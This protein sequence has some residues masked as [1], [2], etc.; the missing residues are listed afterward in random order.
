MLRLG[1]RVMKTVA[2]NVFST[3]G[4]YELLKACQRCSECDTDANKCK[5]CKFADDYLTDS[6]ICVDC[7]TDFES[8]RLSC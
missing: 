3:G 1:L 5:K 8:N 2:F 4:G 6:G 7:H